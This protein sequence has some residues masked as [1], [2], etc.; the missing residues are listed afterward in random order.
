[1][2]SRRRSQSA[3]VG[4]AIFVLIALIVA[5]IFTYLYAEFT[6]ASSLS[7]ARETALSQAYE[8]RRDLSGYYYVQGGKLYIYVSSR[9]PQAAQI[10][11]MLVL[12]SNGSYRLVGPGDL[13]NTSSGQAALPLALGYGSATA[14]WLA[15]SGQVAGVSVV[16][17]SGDVVTTVPLPAQTYLGY[18]GYYTGYSASPPP[19]NASYA[20]VTF[21]NGTSSN[22]TVECYAPIVVFNNATAQD[23]AG[24]QLNLTINLTNSLVERCGRPATIKVSR[25]QLVEIPLGNGAFAVWTGTRWQL[26]PA[27]IESFNSTALH[28]WVR[29]PAVLDPKSKY[30]IYLLFLN[31]TDLGSTNWGV[32]GYYVGSEAYDNI[33]YV[34][35]KGLLYQVYNTN[36][37]LFERWK[38]SYSS[39]YSYCYSKK[40]PYPTYS[41][42]GLASFVYGLPLASSG[43][44]NYTSGAVYCLSYTKSGSTY[45]FAVNGVY[46][47]SSK[48]WALFITTG[49]P[50]VS[51]TI[52]SITSHLISVAIDFG[53]GSF[54]SY[55]PPYTP[56]PYGLGPYTNVTSWLLKAVGWLSVSS[57]SSS[58]DA[59]I[60]TDDG[61]LLAVRPSPAWGPFTNWLDYS[62]PLPQGWLPYQNATVAG[63]AVDNDSNTNYAPDPVFNY[64]S[65]FSPSHPI[66]PTVGDYRV[67]VEYFND[68]GANSILVV[69]QYTPSSVSSSNV[70][71]WYAPLFPASGQYPL[72]NSTV[73]DLLLGPQASQGWVVG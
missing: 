31:E 47:L 35:E 32:N 25:T 34:M 43:S 16:V 10:E 49:P 65:L 17:Q 38:S 58:I 56:W 6:R 15:V 12:F 40:N 48:F 7:S 29:L 14:M 57:T 66:L 44:F 63:W 5:G 71:A 59:S 45:I 13:V 11:Y 26:L 21:L 54:A 51:Y 39:F 61:G 30:T 41:Y 50:Q 20:T 64:T 69:S 24:L 36:G 37:T 28:V 72:V 68:Y 18:Y 8:L 33:G 53:Y 52:S 2:P 1:M 67:V 19:P 27:W 73:P 62:L 55:A 22:M 4:A 3:V 60:Y 46:Y 23:Q 70:I 42:V 9:Y